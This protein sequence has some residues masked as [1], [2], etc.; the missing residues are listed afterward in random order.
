EGDRGAAGVGSETR[1][2]GAAASGGESGAGGGGRDSGSR[3]GDRDR[4][5]ADR[6]SATGAHAVIAFEHAGLDGARVHL[7]DFGAGGGAVRAGSGAAIDAAG[8]GEHTEGPGGERGAR[9]I[10]ALKEGAG[11]GAGV[12]VAAAADRGG[13]VPAE[14]A[15][16]ENAESRV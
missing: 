9:R 6:F 12:A 10:G 13:I 5:G 14:S 15:Q 1:D 16:S 2:A 3:A 7:R 11:G 8:T 4:S